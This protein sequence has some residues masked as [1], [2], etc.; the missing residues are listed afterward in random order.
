M[1]ATKMEPQKIAYFSM[2]IALESDIPTYSGGLGVLSGDTLRS[3]AD[4]SVPIVAVTLIYSGGYFYQ[5]LSPEGNQIE[6]SIRWDFLGGFR[7][8]PQ[9]ITI[10]VQDNR[11]IVGAWKYDLRGITGHTLPIILLD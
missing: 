1:K 4:L 6:K 7:K 9:R 3:A 8:L 11:I 5:I 10:Q 2:E